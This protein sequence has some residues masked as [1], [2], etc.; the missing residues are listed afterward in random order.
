MRG[1]GAFG[2]KPPVPTLRALILVTAG[3]DDAGLNIAK[4][5]QLIRGLRYQL[6]TVSDK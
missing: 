6:V 5:A 4:P 3:L 2:Q 1:R